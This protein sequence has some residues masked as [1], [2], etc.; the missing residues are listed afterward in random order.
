MRSCHGRRYWVSLVGLCMGLLLLAGCQM[1]TSADKASTS[2]TSS[3]ATETGLS[4]SQAESQPLEDRP[5]EPEGGWGALY[6][7]IEYPATARAKQQ[8]GV[9][10]VQAV[11]NKAG[12]LERPRVVMSVS[13]ELDAE[14]LRVVKSLTFKPAV[15]NG[16]VIRS[17]IRLPIQFHLKASD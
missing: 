16:Q 7:A 12:G 4:T 1:T 5:P 6:E 11:V 10:M 17:R 13:P 9:V 3:P 8:E 14:A 2:P 15:Q